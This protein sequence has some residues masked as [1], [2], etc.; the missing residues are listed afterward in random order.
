[1]TVLFEPSTLLLEFTVLGAAKTAGSKRAFI[2]PNTGKAI[3]TD[4]NPRSKPWMAEVRAAGHQAWMAAMPPG[5]SL[6]NDALAV[7][8]TFYRQRPRQHFGQGR[9]SGSLLSSAPAYPAK[10]PDLL[11]LA[12]A[13]EDALTGTIWIDDARIVSETLRKRWCA[14][15]EPERVEVRISQPG[16]EA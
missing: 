7:D 9:N 4:D 6:L 1:M 3:V 13:I 5:A 16:G 12:R 10:K 8:L 11:K 14:T 15:G 2:N